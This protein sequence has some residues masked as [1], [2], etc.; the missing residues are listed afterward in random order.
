M[1]AP[2]AVPGPAD[3]HPGRLG[4]LFVGTSG[5][6]Y[7]AWAPTFYPPGLR[8]TELLAA[9]AARLSCCELNNTFYRH[10]SQVAIAAWCAAT[11][12]SFRFAVKAQKGGSLRAMTSDPVGTVAWLAA[13]YRGFGDRLGC[14]LFRVPENVTRDDE[15]LAA[16]LA[17]WPAD[18]PLTVE[19][20]DPSWAVDEVFDLLRSAGAAWCSTELDEDPAPPTLRLT[21]RWF[22]IRLRRQI[23]SDIEL[24]AWADRLTPF[25]DAGHDC[26]AV[27]RHD[28]DGTSAL[29]ALALA[30]LVAAR[31]RVA[32]P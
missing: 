31:R 25:L 15:R 19:C 12:A 32:L 30:D 3:L 6:S 16:L 26:Y 5:F 1:T 11:P 21:A 8:S 9:Y 17:A 7:P 29:R 22:Y 13:P 28:A 14:V 23:Y 18:L 10:P 2:G 24:A 20:R 27:F 4:R